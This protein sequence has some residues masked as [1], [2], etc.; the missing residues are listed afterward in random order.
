MPQAK[1][2]VIGGTGLYD[3]EG[4]TDIEEVNINTPFGKPSDAITIGKLEGV[5]IALA[6]AFPYAHA[7]DASRA[8]LTRGV[9]LE[10]ISND[11]LFLV[12]WAIAIFAIGVI[13]FRRSMRS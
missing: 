13:L 7:I 2:G 10:A 6:Y 3:I 9:G 12:G 8:I 4:L 1:I 5:G 11:L